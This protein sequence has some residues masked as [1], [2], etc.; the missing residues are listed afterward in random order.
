[1]LV[2]LVVTAAF[3]ALVGVDPVVAN[4]ALSPPTWPTLS[5]LPVVGLVAALAPAVMTP[6]PVAPSSGRPSRQR[7]RASASDNAERVPA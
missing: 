4:P 3:V 1:V 2:G 7:G 5:L 6:P